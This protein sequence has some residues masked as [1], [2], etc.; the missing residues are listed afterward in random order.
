MVGLLI[1]FGKMSPSKENII[2]KH[3]F[4]WKFPWVPPLQCEVQM[5]DTWHLSIKW[6]F[7]WIVLLPVS[8]TVLIQAPAKL[9]QKKN[10]PGGQ[11]RLVQ[12]RNGQRNAQG[13]SAGS[14][15]C[16]GPQEVRVVCSRFI[17]WGMN[18]RGQNR[19]GSTEE[20]NSF[21]IRIIRCTVPFL[22]CQN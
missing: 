5:L 9:R 2:D 21:L 14:F 3:V 17:G 19:A 7:P 6:Y 22:S 12:P 16:R 11:A 15:A 10:T 8:L 1:S 20:K 13:Q 4:P 18:R